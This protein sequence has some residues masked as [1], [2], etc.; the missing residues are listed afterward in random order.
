LVAIGCRTVDVLLVQAQ[1]VIRVQQG[2]CGSQMGLTLVVLADILLFVWLVAME[3]RSVA[4]MEALFAMTT[5]AVEM[6]SVTT[7]TTRVFHDCMIENFKGGTYFY[8]PSLIFVI[9]YQSLW[10]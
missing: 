4:P 3:V 8:V 10:P 5:A 6:Q 7:F 1:G 2:E 9:R